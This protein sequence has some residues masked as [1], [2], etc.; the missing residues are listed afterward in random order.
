MLTFFVVQLLVLKEK[1]P[2]VAP[3]EGFS[4]FLMQAQ[5]QNHF[6]LFMKIP[7][8]QSYTRTISRGSVPKINRLLKGRKCSWF[9]LQIL[10][11]EDVVKWLLNEEATTFP[12]VIML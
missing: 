9:D 10:R 11:G 12:E 4:G 1:L 3:P 2:K 8:R 7:P 6:I 5:Y